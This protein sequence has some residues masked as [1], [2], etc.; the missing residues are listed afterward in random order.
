VRIRHYGILSNR[1][2][3]E[4]LARC[5]EMLTG[6]KA[7]QTESESAVT[8]QA[9]EYPKLTTATRICPWESRLESL[10]IAVIVDN[11]RNLDIIRKVGLAHRLVRCSPSLVVLA[12]PSPRGPAIPRLSVQ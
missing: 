3:R 4:D 7:V 11:I 12:T 10:L 6:G 1:H 9:V 5:R 8:V 2:R